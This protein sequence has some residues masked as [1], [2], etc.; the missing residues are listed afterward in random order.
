MKLVSREGV[1]LQDGEG[2]VLRGGSGGSGGSGG[3]LLLWRDEGGGGGAGRGG[4]EREPHLFASLRAQLRLLIGLPAE[5]PPEIFAP[6]IF[7]PLFPGVASGV[8]FEASGGGVRR[9]ASRVGWFEREAL[10]RRCVTDNLGAL[11]ASFEALRTIMPAVS[12]RVK[13]TELRG[14]MERALGL[15]RVAEDRATRGELAGACAAAV[16]AHRHGEAA[17]REPSLLPTGYFSD[18]ETFMIYA[19]LFL[20]IATALVSAWRSALRVG[21]RP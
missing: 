18:D 12:Y 1:E 6:E 11:E 2:F 19:P 8:G 7:A 15:A 4:G 17:L 14:H 16:D 13:Y 5:P 3:A 9:G 20:P 10:Q 21:R